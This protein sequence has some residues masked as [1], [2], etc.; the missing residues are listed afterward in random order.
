MV[1]GR[2]DAG[3]TLVE[4]L[5]A[6]LVTSAATA[7][8]VGGIA[9]LARAYRRIEERTVAQQTARL[10]LELVGRDLRRAG[11]DPGGTGLEPILEAGDH[12]V[13]IQ[14]D[15]D[16]SGVIDD[17]SEELVAYV[18]RPDDGTL[19]RVVGHQSMPIASGLPSDGCRLGFYDAV[20]APLA[21]EG[22]GLDEPRRSAIRRVALRVVVRDATHAI[23]ADTATEVTLR[24]RAWTAED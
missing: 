18:F 8:L 10:V 23:L 22:S 14:A 7:A 21:D 12:V 17:R 24:N 16:G 15:D 5:M 3:I 13:R 6:I 4:L 19:S 11:F 2:H 9:T 1:A 20:G